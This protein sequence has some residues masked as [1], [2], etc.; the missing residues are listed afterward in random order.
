MSVIKVHQTANGAFIVEGHEKHREEIPKYALPPGLDASYAGAEDTSMEILLPAL[1]F[2]ATTEKM[3]ELV[4]YRAGDGDL[5]RQVLGP[6]RTVAYNSDGTPP[7]MPCAKKAHLSRMA[8]GCYMTVLYRHVPPSVD[9]AMESDSGRD[10]ARIL[11]AL[12]PMM[13]SASFGITET[14]A[15]A[16]LEQAL[17]VLEE[18]FS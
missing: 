1:R 6:G 5:D 17:D 11:A 2:A 14:Y 9:G 12:A 7:V 18:F 10:V 15:T 8:D 4:K 3:L 13:R 16:T